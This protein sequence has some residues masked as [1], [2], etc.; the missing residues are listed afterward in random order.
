MTGPSASSGFSEAPEMWPNQLS[1][2]PSSSDLDANGSYVTSLH[3]PVT[4][5]P[6]LTC[7]E[8]DTTGA[9]QIPGSSRPK[10]KRALYSH[11]KCTQCRE[12][13]LK[14]EPESRQW[15]REKC[16][17][18]EKSGLPCSPVQTLQEYKR[19]KTQSASVQHTAPSI[20]LDSTTEQLLKDCWLAPGW[21]W[22]LD[23]I[24]CEARNTDKT[25]R[26]TARSRSSEV[27]EFLMDLQ[28]M[29]TSVYEILDSKIE[30]LCKQRTTI[31]CR[32]LSQ[33]FWAIVRAHLA[34]PVKEL[35]NLLR[36][37]RDDER[38][39]TR[40]IVKVTIP[41]P[42]THT[43][44]ATEVELAVVANE[45]LNKLQATWHRISDLCEKRGPLQVNN[46]LKI[47]FIHDH[48]PQRSYPRSSAK[49]IPTMAIVGEGG[50]FALKDSLGRTALHSATT[51]LNKD[52]WD[53]EVWDM[54]FY[55]SD[56]A[57]VNATD[58]FGSTPLH[59]ACAA[60]CRESP[61]SQLDVIETLLDA[62]A[63]IDIRDKYGLLAIEYA[64]LGNRTD[65]LELFARSDFDAD[66]ILSA[67]ATAQVAIKKACHI[68]HE[69]VKET[70]EL[71]VEDHC[72][73]C[74]SPI[75]VGSREGSC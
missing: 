13:R 41:E 56:T 46:G 20:G 45:K 47:P 25:L 43:T 50:D 14:C 4:G 27:V 11:N 67:M 26:K 19:Q 1:G 40:T 58:K 12:R 74:F 7:A 60:D 29:R 63:V 18:C 10:R 49:E 22:M 66:E 35:P 8:R 73:R 33:L 57:I 59:I 62:G 54:I 30:D 34:L 55:H 68:V 2:L 6:A 53:P 51:M 36:H 75:E 39:R 24:V 44:Y 16:V 21:C 70:V 65:I 42:L 61:D 9:N 38:G 69:K 32:A 37:S 72:E 31:D 28:R 64:A 5:E 23:K 3:T 52:G 71:Y 17:S 15:P 48:K